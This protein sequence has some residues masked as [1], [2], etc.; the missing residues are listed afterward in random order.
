MA[1]LIV[2]DATTAIQEQT[3]R[4][5][6]PLRISE[7]ERVYLNKREKET[8]SRELNKIIRFSD[9]LR[10][11]WGPGNSGWETLIFIVIID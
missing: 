9:L 6:F 10:K 11:L 3:N 4:R 7:G 2:Y 1:L 5:P 8:D